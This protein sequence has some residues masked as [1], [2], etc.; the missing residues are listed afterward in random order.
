MHWNR[1]AG[2]QSWGGT[3]VCLFSAVL[4]L[5]FSLEE[6]EAPSLSGTS[7]PTWSWAAYRDAGRKSKILEGSPLPGRLPWTL[8]PFT[9]LLWSGKMVLYTF[10]CLMPSNPACTMGSITVTH[11]GSGRQTTQV[12][13]MVGDPRSSAVL[14]S[15]FNLSVPQSPHP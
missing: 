8:C 9:V 2:L 13:N 11:T 5:F 12:Q 7:M 3:P 10:Y 15:S 14:D 6:T 1:S 4:F